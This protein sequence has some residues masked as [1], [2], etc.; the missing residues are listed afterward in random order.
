[1]KRKLS[2]SLLVLAMAGSVLSASAQTQPPAATATG[3]ARGGNGDRQYWLQKAQC[4]RDLSAAEASQGDTHGTSMTAKANAD[5]ITT[6]LTNG[7][8]IQEAPIYSQRYVPSSDPRTGR[9]Q[10]LADIGK[11]DAVLERYRAARCRT[12]LLGCLEVAQ[13]SVYENME[14]TRGARWNHGRPEIDKA[15]ALAVEA[16]KKMASAC[17]PPPEPI[18]IAAPPIAKEIPLSADVLFAFDSAVLTAAGKNVVG[19]LADGI[20]KDGARLVSVDGY[21]DRFGSTAYNEA[22]SSR[23]AAAVAAVIRSKVPAAQTVSIARGSA[24]PVVT[25]PGNKTPETIACLAP[26]RRVVVKTS[27]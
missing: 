13:Q 26:N 6:A 22:L 8:A 24:E 19:D 9:P 25:C 7:T 10:W 16:E 12:P 11:I 2:L 20:A 27:K 1:M 14:E 23:R 15:L 21:T 3:Q 4:W 18:V 5:A 17:E